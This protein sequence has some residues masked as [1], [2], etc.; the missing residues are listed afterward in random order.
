MILPWASSC[1]LLLFLKFKLF[2]TPTGHHAL[3][4]ENLLVVTLSCSETNQSIVK[5]RNSKLFPYP[6][7]KLSTDYYERLLENWFGCIDCSLSQLFLPLV[8]S[9][10]IV[11]VRLYF[12][13]PR[14]QFFM[15]EPNTQK[16]I[17][18]LLDPSFMKDYFHCITLPVLI[19]WPTSS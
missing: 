2:V 10:Y 3:I 18:I 17:T 19:N 11:I 8:L 9:H 12:T 15:R 1:H 4:L 16:S 5:L 13:D 14:V 7:Q 6:L